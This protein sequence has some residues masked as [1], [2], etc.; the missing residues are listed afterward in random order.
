MLIKSNQELLEEFVLP[1]LLQCPCRLP[2]PSPRSTI[3]HFA[4][5]LWENARYFQFRPSDMNNWLSHIE[6]LPRSLIPVFC[7]F[8]V[9]F[10]GAL[11]YLTGDLSLIVF[12]IVPIY[13]AVWTVGR[14]AGLFIAI[15]SGI[16][17]FVTDRLI[18]V[19]AVPLFSVR[20]WNSIMDTVLLVIVCY[21]IAAQRRELVQKENRAKEL[22]LANQTLETFNRTVS[23]DLRQ[24]LNTVGTSCQAINMLCKD[25]LDDECKEFLSIAY[26][27]VQRMNALIRSLL[28]F[29]RSTQG[30]LQRVTVNLS[31][32]VKGVVA[33]MRLI[34]PARLVTFDIAEGVTAN[35]DPAL[36]MSVV[37]NLIGNAWKY[38]C[39]REEGIIAFG[40]TEIAGKT[41]YFVRDNGK[42]FDMADAGK[43]F[44]PF[45]RLPGAEEVK[46]FGIGLSTVDR[47]IRRH[48]GRI[49]AEGEPD[50]G[51]T[52]YFTLPPENGGED[53]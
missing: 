32:M 43:L 9:F 21:V 19:G 52:F 7:L 10:L 41:V 22:E 42:G 15:F 14:S 36:L 11:D 35:G 23:H 39:S 28:E 8:I 37:E 17:I 6:K 31:D 4:A 13:I 50:K 49:W 26:N 53:R 47:I 45:Q 30:D 29:S 3:K 51:A 38:T 40:V 2:T 44:S 16:E 12:Y 1:L 33:N 27:N 20:T 24:P 46:G 34:D 25:K 18:T 5:K 48:G